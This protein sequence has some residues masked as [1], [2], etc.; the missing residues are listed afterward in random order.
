[1]TGR[2]SFFKY[3]NVTKDEPND[4]KHNHTMNKSKNA[5][6]EQISAFK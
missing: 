4:T 5:F 3:P 2:G 6:D 1:M